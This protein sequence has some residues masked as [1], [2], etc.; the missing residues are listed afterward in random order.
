[1]EMWGR[2]KN[3]LESTATGEGVPFGGY[4]VEKESNW[5]LDCI[6]H[7]AGDQCD[8][9]LYIW[10]CYRIV[11]DSVTFAFPAHAFYVVSPM[12]KWYTKNGTI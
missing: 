5:I 1:M 10:N 7:I 4:M 8:T 9:S 6:G 2:S 11:R 3:S 12:R